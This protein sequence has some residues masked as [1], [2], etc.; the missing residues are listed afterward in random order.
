MD[1]CA[2]STTVELSLQCHNLRN[3]DVFSK[4]DPFCVILSKQAANSP[5]REIG[6]TEHIMDTLNPIW[7]KK[8]ILDYKF[9]ERQYL[10]FC[11]YDLDSS[12]STS[13]EDQD[14]LGCLECTLGEV[15]GA[16]SQGF[17]RTFTDGSKGSIEITGE[18]VL[19]SRE[20]LT[21]SFSARKLDKMDWFFGKSDPYLEIYKITE[22]NQNILVHRTEVVKKTL[23][24]D[25]KPIKVHT[26]ALCNGDNERTLRFKVY[27]WNSNGSPDY[28]GSFTTNLRSLKQGSGNEF[29][30]N[31][32]E[33]QS[34]KGSKYTGSGTVILNSILVEI[35]PTFLDFIRAGTQ[36]NFTVAVDFTASNGNPNSPDS[37]HYKG[38]QNQ[39]VSAIQAVGGIIQDYDY[40][41]QFP[42]LGFGAVVPSHGGNPYGVSHEFF[43][44]LDPDNPY[45]NGIDGVLQAYYHSLN[46]V[47]LFGPTN[48]APVIRHVS[49][50]ARAYQDN[51]KEYFVLLIITDG[52][53]TDFE[54]TKKAIVSASTLPLSIIIVGVGSE[55]FSAMDALDSDDTLLKAGNMTAARDIVQFVEMQKFLGGQLRDEGGLAKEVLAEIPDQLISYMKSKGFTP[56]PPAD[57][58][59][60]HAPAAGGSFLHTVP[61]ATTA[62]SFPTPSV[63]P[64]GLQ[65]GPYPPPAV[66]GNPLA[67]VPGSATAPSCPEF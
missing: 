36:V 1:F 4:S 12:S 21:F 10:K 19:A 5:W 16:Q 47:R 42:A 31:N 26:S 50:F 56:P 9:E 39:Y 46:K 61:G 14:F 17:K 63:T 60:G 55:D 30:V 48:F 34:K 2:P 8:F 66:P 53:I 6:R 35:P 62:P 24:P 51:P 25:W 27:D 23:N 37:L 59:P 67:Q 64:L 40:D 57:D 29:N 49:Q 7:H 54:D 28:I 52:I 32:E 58:P 22:N 11:V 45:C 44:N 18:E 38:G 3:A 20:H 43:L 33:K 41:K 65:R 15:M 13:L